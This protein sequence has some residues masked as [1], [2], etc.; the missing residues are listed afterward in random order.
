MPGSLSVGATISLPGWHVWR[1]A[2]PPRNYL[3]LPHR[4]LFAITAE[5]AIA[6]DHQ[7]EFHDLQDD[8]RAWWGDPHA[9]RDR[10]S[11]EDIAI[12]LASYL[13]GVGLKP[14]SVVVSEDGEAFARWSP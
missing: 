2:P 12:S 1:D 7:V 11:C 13:T 8:M 5:V 10:G 6:A 14:I 9:Q 3:A 4:H